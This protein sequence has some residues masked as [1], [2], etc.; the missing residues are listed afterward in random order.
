MTQTKFADLIGKKNGVV[1]AYENKGT[2]PEVE[3]MII[4]CDHF[5]IT[6]DQFIR[7]D[8]QSNNFEP[9]SLPLPPIIPYSE[10]KK[11]N[12]VGEEQ[13]N[14][15]HKLAMF[16]AEASHKTELIAELR[17]RIDELKNQNKFLQKTIEQNGQ[18]H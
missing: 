7:E 15:E 18:N 10:R 12:N 5:Q 1:S 6:L 11:D 13:K 8:L 17:E 9:K 3:S 2:V 16:M 4:I 14:I